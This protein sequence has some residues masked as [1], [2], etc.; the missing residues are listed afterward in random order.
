MNAVV[1]IDETG[2]LEITA[3][4]VKKLGFERGDELVVAKAGVA[5]H[6]EMVILP[7]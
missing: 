4:L 5:E 1:K 2:K 3:D 6:V 7:K